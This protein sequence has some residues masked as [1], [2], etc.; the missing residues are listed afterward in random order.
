MLL[1]AGLKKKENSLED[2]GGLEVR[3]WMGG[4]LQ[5]LHNANGKTALT[6]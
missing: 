4:G 2:G 1:T 6:A 5:H 3:E